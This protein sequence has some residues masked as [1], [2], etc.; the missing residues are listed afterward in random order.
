MN[1]AKSVQLVYEDVLFHLLNI[2]PKKYNNTDLTLSGGC[3]MNSVANGKIIK[4][5]PFKNIYISQIQVML[6]V[7]LAHHVFI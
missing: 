1:I 5:T 3:A 2:I 4:K 7:Q 6:V